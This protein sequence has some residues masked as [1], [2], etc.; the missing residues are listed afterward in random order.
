[1]SIYS[2]NFCGEQKDGDFDGTEL[3]GKECCQACYEELSEE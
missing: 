3:N 1:M 2:C